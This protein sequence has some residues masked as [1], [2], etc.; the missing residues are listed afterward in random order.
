MQLQTITGPGFDLGS[1]T[2]SFF[3]DCDTY[4]EKN[5]VFTAHRRQKNCIN[6]ELFS[7]ASNSW[8]VQLLLDM[9]H[10]SNLAALRVQHIFSNRYVAD[11]ELL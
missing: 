3:E 4:I 6:I 2:L 10:F 1:F 7:A 5:I 9:L 8:I 11:E